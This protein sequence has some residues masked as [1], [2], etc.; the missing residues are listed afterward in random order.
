MPQRNVKARPSDGEDGRSRR[1]ARFE[2]GVRLGGITKSETL[3]HF[4]FDLTAC[5]HVEQLAGRLH[6]VGAGCR[7]GE[8]RRPFRMVPADPK[9]CRS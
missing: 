3:L 2:R 9:N 7:V 1:L 6:Q 5:N 8:K 4:D